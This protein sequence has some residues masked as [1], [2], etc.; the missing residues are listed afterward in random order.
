MTEPDND[1]DLT[2]NAIDFVIR[3]MSRYPE[4]LLQ[5]QPT[6]DLEYFF[7]FVLKVLDGKEPLSK[8]SACEFWVRTR[9][10]VSGYYICIFLTNK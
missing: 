1:S 3:V 2:K 8:T 10:F 6:S 5:I 9:S 7:V 4:A